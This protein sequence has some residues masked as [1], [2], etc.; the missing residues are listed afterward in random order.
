MLQNHAIKFLECA[1]RT[2]R[3]EIL[4][5]PDGYGKM[6]IECG[7]TLE[8]F[9]VIKDKRIAHIAYATNGCMNTTACVNAAID[10]A[11]GQSL[12]R[13]SAI[14]PQEVAEYL[15]TLPQE[16]FHC[17][18]LAVEA[19]KAALA[20]ARRTLQAPWKKSYR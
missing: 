20:D 19:L 10:L 13:A 17:A 7:D 6:S 2:D 11:Q 4:H 15:Q 16:H 8:L 1:F 18:E 5:Q 3:Q 14:T 9:L 12:S